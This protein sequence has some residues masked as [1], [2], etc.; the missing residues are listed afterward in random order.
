MSDN[1]YVDRCKSIYTHA[2]QTCQEFDSL[3]HFS[4][5]MAYVIVNMVNRANEVRKTKPYREQ[6]S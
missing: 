4:S 5:A 2:S 1:V 6:F 3:F